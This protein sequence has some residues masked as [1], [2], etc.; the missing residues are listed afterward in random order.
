MRAP[1]ILRGFDD[2]MRNGM[3]DALMHAG[4]A[5]RFGC[6]PTRIQKSA[7]GSLRVTPSDGAVIEVDE[8]LI[9]TGRLPNTKGLGL[10]ASG[11]ELSPAH[12]AV[13]VDENLT[14]SVPS[15]H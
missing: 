15:I 11:V 2:E 4:I 7:D 12:G 13:K 1:N 3:R 5:F 8:A 10:E 9:A 6:L 14:S